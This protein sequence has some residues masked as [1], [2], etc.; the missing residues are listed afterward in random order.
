MAH[1]VRI[2]W[3]DSAPASGTVAFLRGDELLALA[4]WRSGLATYTAVWPDAGGV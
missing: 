2:P 4:E 1:G 3:P